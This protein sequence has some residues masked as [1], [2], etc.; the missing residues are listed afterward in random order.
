MGRGLLEDLTAERED[1]IACD[2]RVLPATIRIRQRK[3]TTVVWP[4]QYFYYSCETRVYI[5]APPYNN[6]LSHFHYSDHYHPS[7]LINNLGQCAPASAH[8]PLPLS[9]DTRYPALSS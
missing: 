7:P 8:V 2:T 9:F 5:V 6:S 4:S 1:G 3:A